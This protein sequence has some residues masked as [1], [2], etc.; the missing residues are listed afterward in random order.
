MANSINDNYSINELL[1]NKNYTNP[2]HLYIHIPFCKKRCPY[3]SFYSTIYDNNDNTKDLFISALLKE[4]KLKDFLIAKNIRTIYLGGGT[5][6]LLTSKDLEQIFNVVLKNHT[7]DDDI[8]ITIEANPDDITKDL[9]SEW[10]NLGINRVSLG[11]ENILEKHLKFLGREHTASNI[12]NAINIISKQGIN[13]LSVDFIIGLPDETIDDLKENFK[14][15]INNDIPHFSTYLLTIEEKTRLAKLIKN[16]PKLMLDDDKIINNTLQWYQW[17][18]ENGYHHYEI[19]NFSLPNYKSKHN[20]AY[21]IQKN[22]IGFGPSAHSYINP[23]RFWNVTS[24]KK[25]L[26]GLE[27][28]SLEYDYEIINKNE[29]YNEYVMTRLRLKEGI[30]FDDLKNK[31]GPKRA[32]YFANQAC[33]ISQKYLHKDQNRYYLTERG[34]LIMPF[35]NKIGL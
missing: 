26:I 10:K 23:V 28:N 6:S 8:E 18:S 12:R 5:P 21:W 20:L 4:I 2:E 31:F 14:L 16:N 29:A 9:V 25:Y 22:Y 15:L 17:A 3:C 19:S 33:K 32:Q 13:N 34:W 27:N 1:V 24:L 30:Y 7:L 11:V 35:T